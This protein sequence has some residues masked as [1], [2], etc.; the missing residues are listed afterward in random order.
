MLQMLKV[1][2]LKSYDVKVIRGILKAHTSLL[3]I[4]TKVKGR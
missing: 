4:T 1:I 2:L 3:N